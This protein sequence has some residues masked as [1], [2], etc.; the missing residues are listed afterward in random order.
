MRESRCQNTD[1]VLILSLSKDEYAPALVRPA[2]EKYAPDQSPNG[3][4]P[5]ARHSSR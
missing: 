5:M 3:S 1:L 2:S 4:R